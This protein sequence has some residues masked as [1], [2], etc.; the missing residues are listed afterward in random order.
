M[1]GKGR[2]CDDRPA[3]IW[4]GMSKTN[5]FNRLPSP[6]QTITVGSGIS[7]DPPKRVHGL[8][9]RRPH[10]RSGITPCPEGLIT[11]IRAM[12]AHFGSLVNASAYSVVQA[13]ANYNSR[14]NLS[15][16]LISFFLS[17]RVLVTFFDLNFVHRPSCLTIIRRAILNGLDIRDTWQLPQG[18]HQIDAS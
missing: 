18:V 13:A 11:G 6:I 4:R 10:R 14:N 2:L 15:N 16:D 17:L 12:S 8:S 7:P 3:L 9:L 1:R 5:A